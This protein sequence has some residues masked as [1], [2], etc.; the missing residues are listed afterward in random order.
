M[1]RCSFGITLLLLLLMAS[2]GNKPSTSRSGLKAQ[3]FQTVVDGKTTNLYILSNKN[4]MEVC[5]T[6]YGGR[7]VSMMV[8]DRKGKLQDVVLGFDSIGSYLRF[9]SNLGAVVGRYA[10]GIHSKKMNYHPVKDP[11]DVDSENKSHG[12]QNKVFDAQQFGNKKL[13]LTYISKDG[14]EGFPGNLICSITYK[15][16]DDNSLD[17][18]F[19]AGTDRSTKVNLSSYIYFNLSGDPSLPCT[20]EQLI[21]H[22]K[23]FLPINSEKVSSDKIT[24]AIG[25]PMN[26]HK[27]TVID[28]NIHEGWYEQLKN[29]DGFN[30]YYLLSTKGDINKVSASLVS[31]RSGIMMSIFTTEPTIFFY[32]G[33]LLDGTMFGKKHITYNQHAGLVLAPQKY[34]DIPNPPSHWPA[35]ML[36]PGQRYQ[37]H[38]IYQFSTVDK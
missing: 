3:N 18:S 29:G 11:T 35:K 28:K 12:F 30:H 22:A 1:R 31:K 8:P 13:V 9:P 15:L 21:I 4:G 6:N 25:T 10:E 27:P 5:I 34:P 38:T 20:D 33:N 19:D 24:K 37:W 17:I 16:T 7:I 14:E 26:F 23:N 36:K 32:S 2:C